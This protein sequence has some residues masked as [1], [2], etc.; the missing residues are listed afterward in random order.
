[1]KATDG[2]LLVHAVGG[3][4][5]GRPGAPRLDQVIPDLEGDPESVGKQRRPLRKLFEGLAAANVPVAGVVLLGTTTPVGSQGETLAD[6]ADEMRARLVSEAGLCGRRLAADTVAVVRVEAPGLAETSRAVASWLA[7][8]DT[9]EILITCGSG[10]FALGAGALCGALVARRPAHIVHVDAPGEL[11]ALEQ[12][13]EPDRHLVSWLVRY[14]FWDALADLAPGDHTV[15]TLLAA[16]QAGDTGYADALRERPTRVPGVSRGRLDKFAETWPTAQAALFERL[17][18]GEAADYGLLRAWFAGHLRNLYKREK[19][20]NARTR[21]RLAALI[22]ALG[23]RADGE[24]G[25]AGR[26]R[27]V[28]RDLRADTGSA[29]AAMLRDAELV[30]LYALASTHQAHLKPER[31]EPG[32]L[33]PTLIAAADEWERGD[34]GRSLVEATGGLCWPVLGSGDVLG[35]LAVGLDREGRD[36]EDLQALHAVLAELRRRRERLLRRG[37]VRL[38]LLASPESLARAHRLARAAADIAADADVRVI[39]GVAGGLAHVRETVVAA[40]ASEAKPTGLTG[41]ESL[42][43]VDE[44]V[45]ALNP[46]PPMTNYGMIAAAVEWSLT[47]ACPLWVTEL[48]RSSV[49]GAHGGPGVE[50]RTGQRILGRL[51][52]DQVLA[53]L[54]VSAVER[55][56]LR[57]ARRLV[58][59]GSDVLRGVD[60]ALAELENLVFG[61]AL[62]TWTWHERLAVARRRLT[63]IAEVADNPRRVLPT[64]YLAVEA[65]RPAL[66]PW[67]LW[68]SMRTASSALNDL[69]KLANQGVHGHGLDRQ[70]RGRRRR[71]GQVRALLR[72]VVEE[73][74]GPAD[75]D[76]TLLE[77]HKKV[78]ALLEGISRETA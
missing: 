39:E 70:K 30:D 60:P 28:A 27:T 21:D 49:A 18:R 58:R 17:G 5:L 3:G 36:L 16:R 13:K 19:D 11:Y 9:A 76:R 23:S 46:G 52:A 25:L 44:L 4:D 71:P 55:L 73:L 8:R 75:G 24:G 33:P 22:E 10:A 34:Q 35:L 42:R 59:R 56:D 72:R 62:D 45:L 48:V 15:W 74:N 43:D 1:M 47:A 53:R 77:F 57:T 6:H 26:L 65:L 41:S 29:C 31:L 61:P 67:R 14:R 78:I 63:L 64:A 32:P 38:R 69:G 7:G 20:L 40:L 12:R 2:V 51:G 68:Q 66:F 50:V 37:V 54:A